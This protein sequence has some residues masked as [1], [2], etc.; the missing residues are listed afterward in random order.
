M[1]DFVEYLL[2]SFDAWHFS[3]PGLVGVAL[4]GIYKVTSFVTLLRS[5]IRHTSRDESV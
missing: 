5:A 1:K 2:P 4:G 3:A